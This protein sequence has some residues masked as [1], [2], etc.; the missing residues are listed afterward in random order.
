M[1]M[2]L[3]TYPIRGKKINYEIELL[4]EGGK[5]PTILWGPLYNMLKDN[6]RTNKQISQ[7]CFL[8]KNEFVSSSRKT[9]Q[10]SNHRKS[11]TSKY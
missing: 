11:S 1:K 6:G 9:L 10:Q 3:I 8:Q 5:K 2:K 7:T 4:E